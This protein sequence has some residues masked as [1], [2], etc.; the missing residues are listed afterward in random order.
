[1]FVCFF[2]CIGVCRGVFMFFFNV[3]GVR[4][5]V[6]WFLRYFCVGVCE[7]LMPKGIKVDVCVCDCN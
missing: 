7:C 6:I 2:V 5:C 1:M 4:L 3:V